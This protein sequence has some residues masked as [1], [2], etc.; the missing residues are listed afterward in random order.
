MF[1][2]AALPDVL[3]IDGD[4][5]VLHLSMFAADIGGFFRYMLGGDSFLYR[6]AH[7]N[8]PFRSVLSDIVRPFLTS[9]AYAGVSAVAATFIGTVGGM[10]VVAFRKEQAK[11]VV[12]LFGIVPDFVMIL[13]LQLIVVAVYKTTGVHV[14]RV[15]TITRDEP[16][17]LLPL[18]IL[19]LIPAVFI[20]RSIS[21]RTYMVT[22]EDFVLVARAQGLS[23]FAVYRR[24]VLPHVLAALQAD[25]H[26]VTALVLGNLFITEY[27]FNIQGITRLIFSFS[28]MGGYQF[29]LVVTAFLAILVLYGFLFSVLRLIIRLADSGDGRG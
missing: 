27:L 25:L 28:R 8:M 18:L 26:K 29:N 19:T 7:T 5:V 10:L 17:L 12:S 24:H 23:R 11:D 14:A 13:V 22:T 15:A 9:F 21:N 16:A 1:L 2:L 6:T 3:S 4:R 20:L